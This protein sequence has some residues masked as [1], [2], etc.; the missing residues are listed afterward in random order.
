MTGTDYGQL[1]YLV[2]LLCAVGGF[3]LV[4]N[5][6]NVGK[7]AKQAAVWALIFAGVAGVVGFGNDLGR[8][9]QA[10]QAVIA[11]GTIEVP[12]GRDGHYHLTLDINGVPVDFIVDTGATDMVLSLEDARAVGIDPDRLIFSGRA[13]TANGVVGT[14]PV[15]LAEVT[16][17]PIVD[18]NVRAVVN[19][20][21]LFGSLLGMGYL[22]RFDR[23][24]IENDRLFLE[25]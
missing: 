9:L 6:R 7:M 4:Q 25:R 3:V 15:R 19:E 1:A 24:S 16:L 23:I 11:E 21:E 2:L 20:G 5:R 18:R 8:E 22:Q 14:A 10:R 17:G 13:M 12:R